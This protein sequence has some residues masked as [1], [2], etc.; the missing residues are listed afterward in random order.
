MWLKDLSIDFHN[1]SSR[2]DNLN[3]LWNHENIYVMDNHLAAAFCWLQKCRQDEAYNFLHIDQH[4]DFLC[5]AAI[6]EYAKILGDSVCSLD[7]YYSLQYN[8]LPLMR[9][10]NYIKPT[11]LLHPNWFNHNIFAT[12]KS[13]VDRITQCIIPQM[14]IEYVNPIDVN[15]ELDS[16]FY[17]EYHM[18]YSRYKWIVNL[19]LDFFFDEECNKLFDDEYIISLANKFKQNNDRI[20]VL[21]ICL[22]P[23]CCGKDLADGWSNAIHVLDTFMRELGISDKEDFSFPYDYK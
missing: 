9:W 14:V 2:E 18:P 20:Q 23:E 5:N 11:Q 6:D 19:D 13:P 10:D 7:A 8:G 12:Q 4:N 22:S 15:N 3:F 21:T 17:E 1:K 16:L